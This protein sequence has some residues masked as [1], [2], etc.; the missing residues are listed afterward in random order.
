MVQSAAGCL[1]S[2]AVASGQLPPKLNAIIQPLMGGL[3]KEAESLL[4]GE[5]AGGVARML[6]LAANRTPCPNDK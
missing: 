1:A 5:Y 4:Q 6:Q 3:R 2:A